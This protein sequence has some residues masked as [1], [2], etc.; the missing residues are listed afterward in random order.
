MVLGLAAYPQLDQAALDSLVMEKMFVVLPVIN[1]DAQTSL[2]AARCLQAR[3]VLRK[4]TRVAAWAGKPGP[5]DRSLGRP[6]RGM[7]E[8]TDDGA[9]STGEVLAAVHIWKW[10]GQPASVAVNWATSRGNVKTPLGHRRGPARP[11][12]R[13]LFRPS[14]PRQVTTCRTLGR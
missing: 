11:P 9:E 3:D 12:P 10:P 2:W 6:L 7:E 8:P 4:R 14:L 5:G 13:Q 1:K